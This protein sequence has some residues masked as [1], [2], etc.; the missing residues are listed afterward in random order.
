MLVADYEIF[1]KDS[2]LGVLDIE[3]NEVYQMWDISEIK[4]FIRN[5][6]NEIWIRLQQRELRQNFSSWYVNW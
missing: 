2:L 6:L 4:E 1:K 3:T 5:H